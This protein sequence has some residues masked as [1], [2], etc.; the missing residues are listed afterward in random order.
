MYASWAKN[1]RL[2]LKVFFASNIGSVA[3]QDSNFGQEIKWD[4]LYLDDFDH[5]FLNG[6]I[7][8]EVNKNLDAPNLDHELNN[9]K[10]DLVIQ[11]GRVYKFNQRLRKWL[12]ENNV[13]S[14]YISD[15]ENR[16]KEFFLK[17]LNGKIKYI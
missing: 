3:Y 14:G 6:N 12:G 1:E 9:F 5:C 8:L 7:T 4:N 15:T 2:N 11:Y 16:N 10:P 13:K 17:R